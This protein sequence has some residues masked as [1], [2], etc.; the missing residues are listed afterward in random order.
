M[1]FPAEEHRPWGGFTVLAEGE[2][3]KVKKIIVQPGQRLSL[4][5]H[6][7]REEHWS[8]V[9][10]YGM[11]TLNK[12]SIGLSPGDRICIRQLSWHRVAAL[13][14]GPLVIIETQLGDRLEEDD[15][16]RAE[17]DYGRHC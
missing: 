10:G 3:Y 9:E 4:Q 1:S 6:F 5:R 11:L 16:E 12:E 13:K 14:S 17:D 15:I 2:N 7:H 8:V